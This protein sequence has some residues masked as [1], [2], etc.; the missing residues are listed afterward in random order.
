MR[1]LWE[2]KDGSQG[3]GR[4]EWE[5]DEEACT[6]EMTLELGSEG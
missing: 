6:A 4:G 1:E 5:A 2:L 3:P